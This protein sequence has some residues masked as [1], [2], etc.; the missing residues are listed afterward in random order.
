MKNFFGY[1]FSIIITTAL[2]LVSL[3]YY[4]KPQIY[5]QFNLQSPVPDFLTMSKNKQVTLLDLWAPFIQQTY[6][7]GFD[8]SQLTAQSV[9]MYDLSTNKVIFEKN[10]KERLAMASLTKIMTAIIS[11]EHKRPDDKYLVHG[12][13]LVGED[14]MG[15]SAGE[16]LSQEDLLYGLML[17]SGNDAAEVLATNYEGGR[18][19]FI[20]AMNDK[21]KALGLT[22]T[23]FSNPSGL[24]GDGEQHTTA[25][26]LLVITK[27]ALETF[28]EFANVV[29]TG[30]HD[31]PQTPTHKEYH[32]YNET[33]LLTTYPGVKGVKTGFTP[34]AGLCLITYLDYGG[35]KIIG[36]LLK[37]ENRRGEMKELLDYSLKS[38]GTEPPPYVD[39]R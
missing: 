32:L 33:N 36:V 30:E 12:E 29:A 24:Q 11:L 37:S 6:G 10:P 27:Y 28:P 38:L 4:Y 22:D 26:D 19:T 18:D 39:N 15:L 3:W 35:H 20:Q 2:I 31:I 13:N 21:A 25:Y 34:E 1:F 23:R 9:L 7:S 14:S 5:P 16:T 17:P 8:T